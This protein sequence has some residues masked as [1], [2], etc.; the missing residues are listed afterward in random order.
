MRA[1][2]VAAAVAWLV[3]IALGS[4]AMAPRDAAARQVYQGGDLVKNCSSAEICDAFLSGL[5]DARGALMTWTGGKHAICTP[6]PL[7]TAEIWPT[8]STYLQRHPDQ[9]PFY[10]SSVTLNALQE[11]NRCAPNAAPTAQVLD[12]LRDAT[13]LVSLCQNPTLCQAFT[14]GVLDSH[15]ALAD[16]KVIQPMICMPDQAEIRDA[17]VAVITYVG[18]HAEA[19]GFTAGSVALTALSQR[20]PCAR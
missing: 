7:N 14:I 5:F 4:I 16:W 19:L 1:R 13:E 12:R 15:Q 2:K 6:R 8:V 3:T 9:L 20:Y 18:Q 10:A 11:G 17:M